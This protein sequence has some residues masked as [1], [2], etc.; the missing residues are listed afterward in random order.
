MA[1][2]LAALEKGTKPSLP[3]MAKRKKEHVDLETD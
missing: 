3:K 1:N 2:V